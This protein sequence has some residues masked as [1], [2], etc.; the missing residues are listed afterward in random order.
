MS[1]E[2]S[3]ELEVYKDQLFEIDNKIYYHKYK[4]KELQEQVDLHDEKVSRLEED[5]DRLLGAIT[6]LSKIIKNNDIDS[7]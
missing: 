5:R 7:Q 1:N 4:S 6:A 3:N 2:V